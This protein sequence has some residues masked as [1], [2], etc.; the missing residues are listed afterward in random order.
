MKNDTRFLEEVIKD[1]GDNIPNEISLALKEILE[2]KL[3]DIDFWNDMDSK[4]STETVVH[5]YMKKVAPTL[6]N[7]SK[8]ISEILL[9]KIQSEYES[10][11]KWSKK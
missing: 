11:K 1:F 3:K 4:D 9:S 2:K 7:L 6:K 5:D 8:Q 10:K